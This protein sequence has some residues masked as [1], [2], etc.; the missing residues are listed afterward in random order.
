MDVLIK[1]P[2]KLSGMVILL[3]LQFGLRALT[4]EA[5]SPRTPS[6]GFIRGGALAVARIGHFGLKQRNAEL[7]LRQTD[8]LPEWF[9]LANGKKESR[10]Q[11][12]DLRHHFEIL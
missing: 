6:D 2:L 7:A 5:G 12:D 11:K 10:F 9:V 1:Q 4:V 8:D 3:R